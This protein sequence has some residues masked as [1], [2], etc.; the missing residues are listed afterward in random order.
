MSESYG[1]KPAPGGGT[2]GE[3]HVAFSKL[4]GREAELAVQMAIFGVTG[5]RKYEGRRPLP[6]FCFRGERVDN[7]LA[8]LRRE[9]FEFE[10]REG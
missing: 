6:E 8:Q 7:L 2:R 4:E 9:G 10:E 3:C 5:Y 1:Q